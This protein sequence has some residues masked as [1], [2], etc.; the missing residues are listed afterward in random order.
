[1][2]HQKENCPPK[3]WLKRDGRASE[4]DGLKPNLFMKNQLELI[5]LG[6]KTNHIQGI[7]HQGK[8]GT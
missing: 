3:E 5:N 6:L 1:L 7:N 8:G 4:S 2:G